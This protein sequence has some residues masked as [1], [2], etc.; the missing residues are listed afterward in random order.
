MYR[1]RQYYKWKTFMAINYLLDTQYVNDEL[2]TLD[3]F[4]ID[5]QTDLKTLHSDNNH[6]SKFKYPYIRNK[7]NKQITWH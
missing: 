5:I 4:V 6:D 1:L 7:S 3:S 2:E